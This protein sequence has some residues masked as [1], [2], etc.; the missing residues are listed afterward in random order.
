VREVGL[1]LRLPES[2][3]HAECPGPAA[4]GVA[5]GDGWLTTSLYYDANGNCTK[6]QSERMAWNRV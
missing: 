3:D 6:S 1:R 2:D 5:I 4:D